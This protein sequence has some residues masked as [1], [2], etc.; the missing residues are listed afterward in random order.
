MST[1]TSSPSK[2]TEVVYG[3]V[4]TILDL[5]AMRWPESIGV[6]E[7]AADVDLSRSTVNRILIS[8][9]ELA[10]A[11]PLANGKY[12]LGHRLLLNA[13]V[14]S[15]RNHWLRSVR[16]LNRGLADSTGESVLLA[17]LDPRGYARLIDVAESTRPLRYRVARGAPVPLSKGA[18][19]RAILGATS[20]DQFESL[21]ASG[22]LRDDVTLREGRAA[23]HAAIDDHGYV[24]SAGERIPEAMGVAAP[25]RVGDE[26]K[27]ALTLT[28]P[29]AREEQVDTRVLGKSVVSAAIELSRLCASGD[30]SD[31]NPISPPREE[32][33][34]SVVARLITALDQVM[35]TG[36]LSI[37]RIEHVA[38]CTAPTARRLVTE[39]TAE[40]LFNQTD[41]RLT[42]GPTVLAWASALGTASPDRIQHDILAALAATCD[43]TVALTML[44][45][46]N[47]LL[48][49]TQVCAGTKS[50][51]Y[52]LDVGSR[53]PLSAG[54]A[55]KAV[56]AHLP[57]H[58]WSRELT[59]S[60]SSTVDPDAQCEELR[61]IRD[62]GVAVTYGE[63]I[64]DAV[65]VAAPVF[66]GLHVVGSITVSTP[67]YRFEK[68]ALPAL[69]QA[70]QQAAAM[71]TVLM[72]VL[73][74]N[75]RTR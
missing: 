63:Q 26:V 62:T 23:D 39:T 31:V 32:Q 9:S 12:R 60:P 59:Q 58:T 13:W 47:H 11:R 44:N 64:S 8:L 1:R 2:P 36:H 34:R 19:G 48:E 43:E 57:E 50:V 29:R 20:A 72:T 68:A 4:I 10:A 30:Y 73:A 53:P 18:L 46:D 40:G 33:P 70:V 16:S 5:L 65:G 71:M 42:P 21:I 49:I 51:H 3:R 38:C 69:R 6:R 61:R 75:G 37:A 27:G 52:V 67:R 35:L 74:T 28:I 15:H 41:G 66:N 7:I 25:L 55:G 56:L 54:A 17:M 22:R 14:A 24:F 45:P